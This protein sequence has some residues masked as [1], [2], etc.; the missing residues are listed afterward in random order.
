MFDLIDTFGS[1][2]RLPFMSQNNIPHIIIYDGLI[3][4][5]HGISPYWLTRCLL[6]TRRLIINDVAHGFSITQI[7]LSS[8]VVSEGTTRSCMSFYLLQSLMSPC[9]SLLTYYNIFGNIKWR[10]KIN[11]LPLN[12]WRFRGRRNHLFMFLT[13]NFHVRS[14]ISHEGYLLLKGN[15]SAHINMSLTRDVDLT[16]IHMGRLFHENFPCFH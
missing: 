10:Y 13:I 5:H 14:S 7:S 15:I 6:I 1:H 2:Y 11:C 8:L 12:Y 16:L 9:M 4:L 3:L